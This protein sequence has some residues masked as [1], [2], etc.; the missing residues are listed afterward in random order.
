MEVLEFHII[1]E[2]LMGA[3]EI[4]SKQIILFKFTN[5]NNDICLGSLALRH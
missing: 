5:V 1:C 3:E 4:P 2:D